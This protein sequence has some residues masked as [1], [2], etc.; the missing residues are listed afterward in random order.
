MACRLFLE[1]TVSVPVRTHDAVYFLADR[2]FPSPEVTVLE[3]ASLEPKQV[4]G[5]SHSGSL[6]GRGGFVVQVDHQTRQN[7]QILDPAK[8]SGIDFTLL[9]CSWQSSTSMGPTAPRS[10]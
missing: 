6:R 7:G 5:Q 4:D 3:L 2:S 10:I 9:L 8:G 1:W